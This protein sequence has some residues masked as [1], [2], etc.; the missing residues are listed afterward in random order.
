[1]QQDISRT[2]RFMFSLGKGFAMFFAVLAL[3]TFLGGLVMTATTLLGGGFKAPEFS[4]EKAAASAGLSRDDVQNQETK[5]ELNSEYGAKILD[6]IKKYTVTNITTDNIITYM[7]TMPKKHYKRFFSGLENYMSDG[8]AYY[9]RE[10]K[11][12]SDT[13]G[14]LMRSYVDSFNVAVHVGDTTDYMVMAQRGAYVS[15]TLFG[16]MLFI[17]AIMLPVLIQIERNTREDRVS[18]DA[19]NEHLENMPRVSVPNNA[20]S[21]KAEAT[22]TDAHLSV[23]GQSL[24]CPKCGELNEDNATFCSGCGQKI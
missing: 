14:R 12:N 13:S 16:M 22:S 4:E 3:L 15:A 1:M 2:N 19:R 21:P 23:P 9:K 17:L 8:M 7:V 6:I 11:I 18:P 5:V 24:R 10:G 20:S